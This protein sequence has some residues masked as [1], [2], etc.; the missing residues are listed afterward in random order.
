MAKFMVETSSPD[1]PVTKEEVEAP[2]AWMCNHGGVAFRG[3]VTV[4]E[5]ERDYRLP[6]ADKY[7]FKFIEKAMKGDSR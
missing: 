3:L 1:G 2:M 6:K 7:S 4:T 5:V